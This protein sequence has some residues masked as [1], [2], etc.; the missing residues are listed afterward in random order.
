MDEA[1][2]QQAIGSI[3]E[4]HNHLSSAL[5]HIVGWRLPLAGLHRDFDKALA[6]LR[7]VQEKTNDVIRLIESKISGME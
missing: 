7:L 4:A 5:K 3:S 1:G 2:R 6:D